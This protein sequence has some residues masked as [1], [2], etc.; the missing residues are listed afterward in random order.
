MT[1]DFLFWA[2]RGG[3]SRGGVEGEMIL[4]LS[5]VSLSECRR[6]SCYWFENDLL[7][8]C[9]K[10]RFIQ[11]LFLLSP[12]GL[13]F[14]WWGRFGLCLRQTP[15]EFAHSFYYILVSFLSLWPLSVVFHSMN[16]P[17]NSPLSHS[18]LLVLFSPLLVV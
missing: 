6:C 9:R 17:D 5:Y 2:G 10:P 1:Q 16:S 4:V 7:G 18:V 15:T 11:M 8:S 13:T 3:G 12:R 14:S